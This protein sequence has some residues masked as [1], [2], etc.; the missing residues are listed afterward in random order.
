M[1]VKNNQDFLRQNFF[2]EGFGTNS[3]YCVKQTS[4]YE[5]AKHRTHQIQK[6]FAD[7]ESVQQYITIPTILFL[8]FLA[9]SVP[10]EKQMEIKGIKRMELKFLQ[11]RIMLLSIL[12]AIVLS[13]IKK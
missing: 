11:L 6:T 8:M 12:I 5:Q 2:T 1:V 3:S 13:L 4:R 7:N 10:E 9:T